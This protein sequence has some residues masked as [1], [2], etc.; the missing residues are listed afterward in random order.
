[1]RLDT[2]NGFFIPRSLEESFLQLDKIM[3]EKERK[4]LVSLENQPDKYNSDTGGLG[5]WI[6][7]NWGIID[8]SRLQTYF[9]ERN[10]FDPKKISAIIVAQYIKYLKNESQV[11]RNW[12]RTHPRI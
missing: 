2:I 5:I 6:R 9:N 8:G 12:E 1:E 7:T 3:P 4:I 10:L 11:A